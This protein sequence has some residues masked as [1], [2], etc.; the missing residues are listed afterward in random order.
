M[1]KLFFLALVAFTT[2]NAKAQL[3]TT[4][5]NW[6]HAIEK[7]FESQGVNADVNCDMDG[8]SKILRVAVDGKTASIPLEESNHKDYSSTVCITV[9]PLDQQR[10]MHN[11]DVR[12]W[13]LKSNSDRVDMVYANPNDDAYLFETMQNALGNIPRVKLIDSNYSNSAANQT[14]VFTLKCNVLSM[15]HGE[16]YEESKNKE[17]E[18]AHIRGNVTPKVERYLAYLEANIQLLDYNTGEIIWQKRVK[19]NYSTS[20]SQTDPMDNCR[21]NVAREIRNAISSMYPSTAPRA[22]VRG[23]VV[24]IDEIKKDK[25]VSVYI[26]VG[27]DNRVKEGDTFAVLARYEI[28]GNKGEHEIGKL[29]VT[30]VDGGSIAHCKIKKGERDIYDAV[31]NELQLIVISNW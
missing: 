7:A 24:K 14:N 5:A 1:K 31:Q 18:R 16:R 20:S 26:N 25:V 28:D 4:D 11:L 21:Q 10:A 30:A 8:H 2:I 29:Q 19:E 22:S 27:E 13:P 9:E 23:E 12:V 15:L 3:I 17:P 6:C